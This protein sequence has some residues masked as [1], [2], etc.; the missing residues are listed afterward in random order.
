MNS[1]IQRRIVATMVLAAGLGMS[2]AAACPPEEGS[3]DP[4]QGSERNV[5]I[6]RSGDHM[7]LAAQPSSRLQTRVYKVGEAESLYGL[8]PA[9]GE[10]VVRIMRVVKDGHDVRVEQHGDKVT[11]KI[12]GK[13]VPADAVTVK[14]GTIEVRDAEGKTVLKDEWP[15]I[16][17]GKSVGRGHATTFTLPVVPPGITWTGPMDED[18]TPKVML[19]ITMEGAD[20][21]IIEQLNLPKGDYAVIKTVPEGL[22]AAKAGLQPKDIIVSVDGKTPASAETIREVMKEKK[23]GDKLNIEV[24]RKGSRVKVDIPLEAF[25]GTRFGAFGQTMGG[26]AKVW[27][28]YSEEMQKHAQGLSGLAM[29]DAMRDRLK[30]A[31]PR[32]SSDGPMILMDRTTDNAAKLEERLDAM[33]AQLQRLEDLLK[34]LESRGE[35]TAPAPSGGGGTP[36]PFYAFGL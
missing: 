3:P 26:N 30:M 5:L 15:E 23:P 9:T 32:G 12:D 20:D 13:D 4:A 25:D 14:D 11:A 22:P 28:K 29:D 7:I 1:N 36:K 34:R 2:A 6:R 21:E 27:Q 17:T 8:Q 33:E 31:I 24:A 18:S 35:Q 10:N 19:G 16:Q